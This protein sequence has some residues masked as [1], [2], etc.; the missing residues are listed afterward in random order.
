LHGRRVQERATT[1][2]LLSDRA[3]A[4]TRVC[5]RDARSVTY[6]GCRFVLYPG[7][8]T[9]GVLQS[10]GRHSSYTQDM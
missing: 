5:S 1:K 10:L 4:I 7:Y 9:E 8:V 6:P 3:P 2:V